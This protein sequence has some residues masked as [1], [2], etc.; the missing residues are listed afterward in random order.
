M[1]PS[2]CFDLPTFRKQVASIHTGPSGSLALLH[3]GSEY[4]V[5]GIRGK[6]GVSPHSAG[7]SCSRQHQRGIN[8][9]LP[10]LK[11]QPAPSPGLTRSCRMCVFAYLRIAHQTVNRCY[12]LG[13][14]CKRGKRGT[15]KERNPRLY[16]YTCVL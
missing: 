4:P 13:R 12:P 5:V 15:K 7:I 2:L 14:N 6:G 9:Y 8:A 16:L 3:F 11:T 1:S 10:V